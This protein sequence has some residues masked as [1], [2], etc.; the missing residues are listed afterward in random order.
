MQ[1]PL[2]LD[3]LKFMGRKYQQIRAAVGI[4]EAL[5]MSFSF[6]CW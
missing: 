1:Q 5:N 2:D 3:M 6:V 4:F